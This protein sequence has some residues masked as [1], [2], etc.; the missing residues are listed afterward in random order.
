MTSSKTFDIVNMLDKNTLT[1]LNK[2]YENRLIGK[3]YLSGAS[4]PT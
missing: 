4:I 1:R 2:D 3:I